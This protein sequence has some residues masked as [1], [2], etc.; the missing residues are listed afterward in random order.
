MHVTAQDLYVGEHLKHHSKGKTAAQALAAT[1]AE[2]RALSDAAKK[3]YQDAAR[4]ANKEKSAKGTREAGP[5]ATFVGQQ[6]RAGKTM[7][8]AAAAWNRLKGRAC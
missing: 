5:Y 6:M 8:E 2:F 7:K 4:R 1:R 3:E